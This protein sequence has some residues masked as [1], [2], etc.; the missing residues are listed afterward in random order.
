[1]QSNSNNKILYAGVFD[2]HNGWQVS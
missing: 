2:G 1:M